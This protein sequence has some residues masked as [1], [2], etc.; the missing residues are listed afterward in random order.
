[1]NC[2][3]ISIGNE[4]LIG[5]T[6]NTN[7]S[8]LGS[9]LTEK[10]VEVLQVHTVGDNPSLMHTTLKES[11]Q[12]ADLVITTGGLGPTHDDVTK[13]VVQKHFDVG[14][15]IHEPTLNYIR[16][17][18]GKRGIPFTESNHMQAEVP[19]NAEVLFNRQGTAPGLWFEEGGDLLA[20]LPGVPHEMKKLMEEKVWPKIKSRL[21]EEECRYS[22]YVLTAGIG[23]STLSDQL[24]GDL[25]RFLS[26]DLSVAYLPSPWGVRIRISGYGKSREEV[27]KK[28]KPVTDYIYEKA[29]GVIIGEGKELSL[30]E[31]LGNLLRR[32]NKTISVAE[33]CTGGKVADTL[34]DI[35]GSSD[36]MMGGVV[37]YSND[38][39]RSLLD[40][41]EADL[42]TY[43]AVSK[44]VAL[45]MAKAVAEKFQ[46]DVGISTT[47]IAGPGGGTDEKPVGTVWIGIWNNSSHFALKGYFTEDRAINKKRSAAVAL[48]SVRRTFLNIETMPYDLKKHPA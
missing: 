7:A 35:P 9:Y 13:K 20:V 5:D 12:R 33:S 46:T 24:I 34:T 14:S 11:L 10:G 3:I 32:D 16:K 38:A 29:D 27:E 31:A 48:E 25:N 26:E 4:L 39:K 41:N 42:T 19:E 44:P 40:V 28:M 22:R 23:E 43:G 8:W 30:S 37:A 36:Y 45:Q 1:M 6:V 21:G 2:E 17:V 15:M 47:G 18:F